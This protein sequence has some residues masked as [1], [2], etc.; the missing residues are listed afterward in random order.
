MVVKVRHV[1]GQRCAEMAAVDDQDPIQQL[2]A[3]SSDPSFGNRVRLGCP[4]RRAEDANTLTGEHG[5]ENAGELAVAVPNQQPELSCAVAEVHQKV[6]R[7]LSNPDTTRVGS[8][9]ENVDATSRVFHHEQHSQLLE[10]QGVDAEE[11]GGE[12]A[13]S[14]HPQE[15]P[16]A[17]P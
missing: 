9:S 17:W 10:Q 5:I 13:A 1:L 12:N 16:P 3:D 11:V 15:L 2:T 6:P 4:H 7:L 8:D 14:L